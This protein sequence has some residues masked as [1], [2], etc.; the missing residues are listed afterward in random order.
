LSV[1]RNDEKASVAPAP[2][3]HA[4]PEPHRFYGACKRLLDVT[5]SLSLLVLAVP[6]IAL[7]CMAIALSTRRSP[8]LVQRRVGMLGR[9]FAMIKLR[10]M[11]GPDELPLEEPSPAPGEVFRAKTPDD[12]RV[13]PVGRL[14]RRTSLDEL[15]QLLNV[16]AGQM[17]LVGPRPALPEEVARYPRS[18]RGRLTVKPGLTGLWQVSG[19]SS[20]PPRRRPAMDRYYV[21]HRSLGFDCLILVRTVAATVSMRGAW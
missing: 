21:R 3:T 17:S 20:I 16:L 18:W 1:L 13:T 8:F 7:A 10:T 11:A 2:L 9:E 5:L 14:L 19:R 6:I 4:A 12:P 15:P